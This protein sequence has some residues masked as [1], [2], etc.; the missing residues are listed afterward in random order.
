MTPHDEFYVGYEP[1]LPPLMARRVRAAVI[2]AATALLGVALLLTAMQRPLAGSSFDYGQHRKWSGQLVRTPAPAVLVPSPNGHVRYWL[3]G[4]GKHGADEVLRGI[5]D[6]W[7]EVVGA[8]VSREDW[9]MIEAA[10]VSPAPAPDGAASLVVEPDQPG[11]TLTVRGEIVDSKCFL[12]VMNPGERTVHRD[13]AIRCLNGGVPPMLAWRD[14][15]GRAGLAVLVDA[16]GR[17]LH[18]Q[19]H[20]AV[21][22]KVDVSGRLFQV[23]GQPVFQLASIAGVVP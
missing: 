10:S 12:G 11:R 21:G 16:R 23:N 17:L 13:C 4:R 14:R 15:D 7:I 20:H 6:G 2:G 18:E 22:R 5:H 19:V 8:L 9:R 3:V 1:T